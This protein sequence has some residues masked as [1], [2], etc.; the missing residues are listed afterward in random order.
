MEQQIR[1]VLF[2]MD[3][4]MFDTERLGDEVWRAVAGKYGVTMTPE[5]VSLLRGRNYE[6]G[7]R[8]FLERFGAGFPYDD[9]SAEV[10]RE[11]E[12]RLE[13]SVPLRPGLFELLDALRARNCKMAVASST[14]S[15]RVLHNLETAG[16]RGYFSAVIGG[17]Q[18]THSKPEP[19]IFLKAAAARA[20]HGAGGFLQRRAG[21][22]CR[23]VLHCD[24]AGHGPAHTRNGAAGLGH[25]ARADGC[26]APAGADGPAKAVTKRRPLSSK[27]ILYK[28]NSPA[29]QHF[30][31]RA[32]FSYVRRAAHRAVSLPEIR[33]TQ[34]FTRSP[35][36]AL[37]PFSKNACVSIP[38]ALHPNGPSLQTG[39]APG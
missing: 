13:H 24:G 16:V 11:V 38:A 21:G 34:R 37:P 3:G 30:V 32:V 23:R 19:E 4:L 18:V 6:S 7:R 29:E 9:M 2:D 15:A 8:A 36:R 28:E 20:V 27:I 1:A 33:S 39:F 5:D 25:R 22:R 31:P 14:D 10:W 12:A 17:D 26:C 35:G